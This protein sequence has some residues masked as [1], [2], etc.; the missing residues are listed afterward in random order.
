[1]KKL[2]S[3]QDPGKIP[4]SVRVGVAAASAMVTVRSSGWRDSLP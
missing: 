2:P 1:M 4:D 3:I